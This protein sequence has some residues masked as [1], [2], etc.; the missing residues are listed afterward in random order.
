[1]YVLMFTAVTDESKYG[2]WVGE[3]ALD[4]KYHSVLQYNKVSD[5]TIQNYEE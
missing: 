1:M 4:G 2:K 3:Y 5:I